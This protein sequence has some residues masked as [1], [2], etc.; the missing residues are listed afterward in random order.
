M[1]LEHRA[2]LFTDLWYMGQLYEAGLRK[3]KPNISCF[4]P[5]ALLQGALAE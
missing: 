5:S 3:I 2:Q 4:A 1:T